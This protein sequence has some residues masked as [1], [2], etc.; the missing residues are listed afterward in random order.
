MTGSGTGS[1]SAITINSFPSTLP[2]ISEG[3]DA[4]SW[5]TQG[6]NTFT[7]VNGIIDQ[8]QFGA[9]EGL[10]PTGNDVV[11]CLN[12]GDFFQLGG[13]YVCGRNENYLGDGANFVY[14]TGGIGAVEFSNAT[15]VPVSAPTISIFA[16]LIAGLL[17]RR[18]KN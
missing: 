15:L 5:L 3:N 7:V 14:N 1:A 17:A 2:S 10:V 6:L 9:S 4:T 8:Y 13:V 18:L 16:L 11:F 12:D